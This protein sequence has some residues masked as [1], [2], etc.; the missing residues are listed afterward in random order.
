[1]LL[2]ANI[3]GMTLLAAANLD[4]AEPLLADALAA[5][6]RTLG[7]EKPDTLISRTNWA[8]L[9]EERG[10]TAEAE[11]E[12]NAVL[13]L[14]R[15]SKAIGP[16]HRDTLDSVATLGRIVMKQE[17]YGDAAN[18]LSE[19]LELASRILPE[20]HFR[21]ALIQHDLGRCLTQLERAHEAEPLLTA[22]LD[23]LATELAPDDRRLRRTI[24]TLIGCYEST[25]Q[26]DQ[27]DLLRERLSGGPRDISRD[28]G[29]RGG[30]P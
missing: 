7:E 6:R 20:S 12:C 30:Q 15:A 19:A 5:R 23:M 1:V 28:G 11:A 17:R 16:E 14:R 27:A 22:A 21:R 2:T 24:E 8:C 9:L 26:H 25:G 3:L 18:L 29:T 10:R 13:V 4:E